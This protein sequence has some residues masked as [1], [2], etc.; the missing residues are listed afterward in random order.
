MR[1]LAFVRLK[2]EVAVNDHADRKTWPDR[3]RGL[4]VEIALNNLLSGLV[5]APRPNGLSSAHSSGWTGGRAADVVGVEGAA[6]SVC[7]RGAG[8]MS[9]T[10]ELGSATAALCACRVALDWSRAAG[11]R[12][13]RFGCA[14][15]FAMSAFDRYC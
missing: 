9:L 3:Q 4:D 8:G 11:T 13:E 6:A 12:S 2:H 7:L 10:C 14:D 15:H 1:F 5:Q